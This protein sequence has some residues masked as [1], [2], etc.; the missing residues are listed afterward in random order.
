MRPRR[1]RLFPSIVTGQVV[2]LG[3]PGSENVTVNV[4][5]FQ[6]RVIDPTISPGPPSSE[7]FRRVK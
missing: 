6:C 1:D 3:S 5:R 7:L 4:T 2:C